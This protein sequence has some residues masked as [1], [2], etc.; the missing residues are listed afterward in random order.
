[1]TSVRESSQ[2]QFSARD[3]ASRWHLIALLILPWLLYIANP[4]W[5]F[6]GFGH[7]DPWYYFGR[8]LN[9]P[10]Y[11]HLMLSY[12]TERLTWILPARLFVILFTP[13]LGWLFFHVFVYYVSVFSIY[14]IA[15]RLF[16]AKTALTTATLM[17][18]NPLFI[19]SNGWTYVDSGTMAYLSLALASLVVFR[20]R[21]N[22]RVFLVASG[23]FWAAAAYTYPAW[24]FLTP[25]CA[26]FYWAINSFA[27]DRNSGG[28]GTRRLLVDTGVF[29]AGMMLTTFVMQGCYDFV[30][31]IA[32]GFFYQRSIDLARSIVNNGTV[33]DGL[34]TYAWLPTATWIVFPVLAAASCL[35]AVFNSLLR[36]TRIYQ[37]GVGIIV[38]YL[39]AFGVFVYMQLRG[40]HR[41]EADF[42]V[43][44]LIP[45]AFLALAATMFTQIEKVETRALYTI[46]A[47]AAL[48]ESIP[49]IIRGD[50]HT[51]L[52]ESTLWLQY[53]VGFGAVGASI[54]WRNQR[55]SLAAIL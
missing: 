7:M 39:Y 38:T 34:A 44:V 53:V 19:G 8:S 18:V 24:W 26:T 6:Q 42:Y 49:L 50:F 35:I 29:V 13:V 41:L 17:A 52:H 33:T 43:S 23:A 45:L 20:V 47:C 48:L 32:G 15:S 3:A 27:T 21:S 37:P 11:D 16:G 51:I 9:F 54:L 2:P 14:F 5:P 36:K 55:T 1:M 30:H 25:C 10:R 28:S 4:N 46:L 12:A 40:T 31:G 22:S